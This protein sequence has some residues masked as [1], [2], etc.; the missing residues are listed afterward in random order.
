MPRKKTVLFLLILFWIPCLISISYSNEYKS[1]RLQIKFDTQKAKI[2]HWKVLNQ[3]LSA[4]HEIIKEDVSS[5]GLEGVIEGYP[6]EYWVQKGGGW[7]IDQNLDEIT[8][9][10]KSKNLP[11]ELR[12][13]WKFYNNS[14]QTDLSFELSNFRFAIKIS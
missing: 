1:D 8:F 4:P 14:Y 3:S 12:K 11:F 6:L 13:S 2:L 10:L 5:F 7:N 9:E